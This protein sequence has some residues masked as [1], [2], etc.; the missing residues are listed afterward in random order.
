V[1]GGGIAVDQRSFSKAGDRD[2]TSQGLFIATCRDHTSEY[3][4]A[5]HQWGDSCSPGASNLNK[6][7]QRNG[8]KAV[9]R[10]HFALPSTWTIGL[11]AGVDG[12]GEEVEAWLCSLPLPGMS[13]WRLLPLYEFP[14]P[15]LLSQDRTWS[16]KN[17]FIVFTSQ[18]CVTRTMASTRFTAEVRWC[19]ENISWTKLECLIINLSQMNA[20]TILTSS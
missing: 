12:V 1:A 8:H 11:L 14:A 7:W 9:V 18:T 20:S 2:K 19:K 15:L 3:A 13:T 4:I 5:A 10:I 17:N 6:I 16:L